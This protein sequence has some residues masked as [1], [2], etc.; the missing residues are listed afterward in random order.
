MIKKIFFNFVL[1]PLPFLIFSIV[2]QS[3]TV[4]FAFLHTLEYKE[5]SS[6]FTSCTITCQVFFLKEIIYQIVEC[7]V[8]LSSFGVIFRNSFVQRHRKIVMIIVIL[9][10]WFMQLRNL[11]SGMF[12]GDTNQVGVGLCYLTSFA[13]LVSVTFWSFLKMQNW[14]P[15]VLFE[16]IR[17]YPKGI[18]P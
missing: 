13:S 4:Y 18:F 6:N 1:T 8:W 10:H 9:L 3:L 11:P 5:D 12:R 7:F 14:Y 2:F 16:E 17:K 15:Y